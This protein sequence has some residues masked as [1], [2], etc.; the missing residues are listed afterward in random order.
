MMKLAFGIRG[1]LTFNRFSILPLNF[2][3]FHVHL[4]CSVLSDFT[5]I[6]IWVF[7]FGNWPRKILVFIGILKK[8]IS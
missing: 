8:T 7:R 5:P 6:R 1:V 2:M 4:D 3:Y